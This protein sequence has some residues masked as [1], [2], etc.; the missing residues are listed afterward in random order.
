M[1]DSDDCKAAPT[2]SITIPELNHEELECLLEFLYS[3]TLDPQKLEKHV[4]A[5]SLA[6]DKYEIPYLHKHC[7]RY[8]LS[9][10][11]ISNALD[12]LE[13][14]DACSSQEL[15]NTTMKFLV[16]NIGDVVLSDRFQAF[17]HASPQL[18]VQLTRASVKGVNFK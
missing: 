2:N 9:S 5:L 7:E 12:V 15:K 16:E 17:V 11:C 4:Y 10:L 3:G 13:I 18:T 1:L 6:A 14:A 8:M